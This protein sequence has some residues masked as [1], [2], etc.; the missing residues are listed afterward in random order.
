VTYINVTMSNKFLENVLQPRRKFRAFSKL[1]LKMKQRK[2]KNRL[3]VFNVSPSHRLPSNSFPYYGPFRYD[4]TKKW[5][6]ISRLLS[7][8]LRK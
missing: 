4:V 3:A 7:Y 6:F 1:A 5:Q 2:F 8:Q